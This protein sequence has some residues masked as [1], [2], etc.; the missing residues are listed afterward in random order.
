MLQKLA[1]PHY[2]VTQIEGRNLKAEASL[3]PWARPQAIRTLRQDMSSPCW[4]LQKLAGS[5]YIV[6]QIEVE[7]F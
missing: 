2:I 5:H 3:Q 7:K 1:C 6:T 4:L